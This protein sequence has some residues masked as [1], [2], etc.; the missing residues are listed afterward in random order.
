[1]GPEHPAHHRRVDRD[2]AAHRVSSFS[3]IAERIV[4]RTIVSRTATL[5]PFPESGVAPR[6]AAFAAARAASSPSSLPASAA[7]ASAARHGTGAAAP[8]TTD[9]RV[10]RPP[11]RSMTQAASAMGQSYDSFWP[12]LV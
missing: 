4:R 7:S 12:S 1:L 9:A 6:S 10:Q 5:Y 2:R 8:S 11:L 3:V